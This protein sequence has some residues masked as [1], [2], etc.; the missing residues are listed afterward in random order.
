MKLIIECPQYYIG[1]VCQKMELR[2]ETEVTK[3]YGGTTINSNAIY[4]I[5]ESA[6]AMWAGRINGREAGQ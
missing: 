2:V 3:T 4:C 6:C 1:G 5:H